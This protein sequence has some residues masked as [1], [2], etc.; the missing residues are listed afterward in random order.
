MNRQRFVLQGL[1]GPDENYEVTGYPTNDLSVELRNDYRSDRPEVTI[2]F[3]LSEPTLQTVP[4]R[5]LSLWDRTVEWLESC[6]L[7]RRPETM[8]YPIL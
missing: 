4:R 6:P 3:T 2:R 5:T 7:R 1:A 8:A